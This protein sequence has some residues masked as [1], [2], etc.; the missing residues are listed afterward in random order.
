M[1]STLWLIGVQGRSD[2]PDD[3]H[4]EGGM[5]PKQKMVT[6]IRGRQNGQSG[7]VGRIKLGDFWTRLWY[8]APGSRFLELWSHEYIALP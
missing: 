7:Q 2:P 8:R 3:W 5:L 6:K 1:S 4:P